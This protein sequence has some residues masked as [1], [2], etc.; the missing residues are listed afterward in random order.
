MARLRRHLIRDGL[1]AGLIGYATV[2]LFFAVTNLLAGRSPFFTLVRLGRTLVGPEA[3]PGSEEGVGAALVYNLLHLLV[4]AGIGLICAWM[5]V[6]MERRSTLWYLVPF[7][8][9]AALIVDTLLSLFMTGPAAGTMRW[10]ELLGVNLLAAL[11]MGGYLAG[12]FPR[13]RKEGGGPRDSAPD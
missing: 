12:T 9:V 1:V 5:T 13:R 3:P 7:V 11:A 10:G 2:A 6:H 8:L 4:F